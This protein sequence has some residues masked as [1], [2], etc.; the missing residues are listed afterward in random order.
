MFHAYGCDVAAPFTPNQLSSC[1]AMRCEGTL[2]DVA[3]L[4]MNH[5]MSSAELCM[6]LAQQMARHD[7]RPAA[8]TFL[9]GHMRPHNPMGNLF[10]CLMC[11]IHTHGQR[12][13]LAC[14][15]CPRCLGEMCGPSSWGSHTHSM[16]NKSVMEASGTQHSLK[17]WS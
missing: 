3:G 11:D 17:G 13:L 8:G 14:Q 5:P 7:G 1:C 10:A 12:C 4:I 2:A 9:P 16:Y 6:R 15:V